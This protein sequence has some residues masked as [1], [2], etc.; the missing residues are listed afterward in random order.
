MDYRD[1]KYV[2][3][4]AKYQNLTKAAEVLYIGQ[5][6]LSK[7]LVSLEHEL[8]TPLFRKIGRRY[9]LTYAGERYV[10]KAEEI[11]RL[12]DELEAE[13]ND[14]VRNEVGEVH[15]AFTAMRSSYL[16]PLVLPEFRRIHPN[17][18]VLILEGSSGENDRRLL[19][20]QVETAFYS[21]PSAAHPQIEYL[22][23]ASEELLICTCKDHPLRRFA[24]RDD[25][26]P[27]PKLSLSCLEQE[28]VLMMQPEQRTRQIVDSILQQHKICLKQIFYT[29]NLQ[30]LMGLVSHGYGVSFVFE[31]HLKHRT[32]A[33]PIDCYSIGEG[34]VFGDFVAAVRRG[35]YLSGYVREFI[36]LVHKNI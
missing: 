34:R 23:L 36:E 32:D 29:G 2:L 3:A 26:G 22:P 17:V 13:M 1:L 33:L 19:S 20:G 18:K 31:S 24:F 21:R 27:R 11:L 8:G 25:T 14:I 12:K 15:A 5:P 28:Q 6:T 30:A 16:L 9:I 4:I 35:S 10:E 7:F